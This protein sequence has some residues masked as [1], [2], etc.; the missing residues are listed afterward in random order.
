MRRIRNHK[1]TSNN[2]GLMF[3]VG[4]KQ[5]IND[6]LFHPSQYDDQELRNLQSSANKQAPRENPFNNLFRQFTY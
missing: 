4:V 6:K 2:P 3:A 1:A 5:I